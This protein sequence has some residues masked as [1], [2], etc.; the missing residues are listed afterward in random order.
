MVQIFGEN[1]CAKILSR[2]DP[3]FFIALT[4]SLYKG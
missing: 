1:P 2:Q 3:K 4:D